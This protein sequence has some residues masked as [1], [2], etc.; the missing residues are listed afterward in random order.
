HLNNEPIR[1][2]PP[3]RSYQ[4]QKLVRRHRV[5]VIA[6]ASITGALIAG[7]G[8]SPCSFSRAKKQRQLAEQANSAAQASTRQAAANELR[9]RGLLTSADLNLAQQALAVN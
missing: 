2:R 5:A 4:F 9:A 8:F 1:A 6:A 3:S 7:I